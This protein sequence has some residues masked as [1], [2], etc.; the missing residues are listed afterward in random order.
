MTVTLK[1][2]MA[3]VKELDVLYTRDEQ[4]KLEP[5]QRVKKFSSR[6]RNNFSVVKI[7]QV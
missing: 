5:I 6:K 2:L 4:V 3:L 1:D 7:P